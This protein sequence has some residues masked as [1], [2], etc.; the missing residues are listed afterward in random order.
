MDSILINNLEI[1]A[2]HGVNQQEK[3][4]GQKFLLSAKI[5][6]DIKEASQNDDLSKTVNYAKLCIDIENEFKKLQI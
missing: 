1:Y 5:F 6:I 3:E 4:L 2:F